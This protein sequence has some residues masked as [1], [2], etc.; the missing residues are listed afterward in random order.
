LAA[1]E[2]TQEELDEQQATRYTNAFNK[3]MAEVAEGIVR[4]RAY[5]A[6][7]RGDNA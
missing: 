2:V 6:A 3:A 4:N 5:W 1:G 7:I